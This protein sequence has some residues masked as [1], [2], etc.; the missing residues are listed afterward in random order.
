MNFKDK[1]HVLCGWLL[2]VAAPLAQAQ[3]VVKYVHTDFM[4]TPVAMTDANRNVIQRSEYEP[5]GQ[6]LNR[7]IETEPGFG[8][9]IQDE[10]TGLTYMEQRYYDPLTGR[11]IS[12]D[13]VTAYEIPGSNFNRYWYAENS[14]FNFIDPNGEA[15]YRN[16][17][18]MEQFGGLIAEDQITR[19]A[20]SDYKKGKIDGTD[21][22]R[23]VQTFG[24]AD[25][26]FVEQVRADL[27]K[28]E[29][30]MKNARARGVDRAW[31]A[32]RQMVAETGTGTRRWTRAQKAELITTGRIKGYEGHHIF[33]VDR[34][35]EL[36]ADPANVLFATRA[37][38]LKMH[39]N[40]FRN[41]TTGTLLDRGTNRMM[42]FFGSGSGMRTRAGKAGRGK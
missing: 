40:N 15:P 38:H 3:G 19:N 29:K 35:P 24:A 4:G 16:P 17:W 18:V 27:R 5:Y 33:S 26:E 37:E 28:D 31:S 20:K 1:W 9:H 8:G 32:E 42:K 39:N 23:T 11:F 14:P 10:S 6:L 41:P 34:Y 12:A 7:A 21:A 2:L 36:A 30:G 25:P 13:P 22:I